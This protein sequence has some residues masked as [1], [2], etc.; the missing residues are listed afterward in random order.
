MFAQYSMAAY[1]PTLHDGFDRSEI[2]A[3]SLERSC[4]NFD[5]TTTVA[6]FLNQ[7]FYGVG[8]YVASNPNRRHIV[9][10]F[11]GSDTLFDA[12]TDVSKG[13]VPSNDLCPG[14]FAHSGFYT[15]LS[16]L[17]AHLEHALRAE[18][19][20][21]GRRNY[22]IV[23]TGHSLGGALATLAGLWLRN[24]GIR[25]D[26]YTYGAPLVGNAALASH[27]SSQPGFTARVTNGHDLVTAIPQWSWLWSKPYAHNFPE[28]WYDHGLD[29]GRRQYEGSRPRRCWDSKECSSSQCYSLWRW[30]TYRGCSLADHQMYGGPF[31]PC[32][33]ASDL[34]R[35]RSLRDRLRGRPDVKKVA[36]ML[37]RFR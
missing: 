13:L 33:A 25:C 15:A 27:L 35:G 23:I 17:R 26:I 3:N 30:L 22:R 20:K 24:R 16:R 21:P 36:N 29:G 28:Y 2:C 9:V 8:G 6:E 37:N 14:C 12:H 18:L 1:C 10:A 31:D 7:D 4:P 11:K 32:A 5:N 19:R 34:R